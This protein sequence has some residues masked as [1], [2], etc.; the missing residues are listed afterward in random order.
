MGHV[1]A[2]AKG[3]QP[4]LGAPAAET[5]DQYPVGLRAK[6]GAKLLGIGESTFWRIAKDDPAFPRGRK[7]TPR[8]TIF[9]T[10]E[11]LA[12]RDSKVAT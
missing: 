3:K 8:T 12:W 9:L 7:L 4:Q 2:A 5:S 11:L 10:A 1:R 6:A